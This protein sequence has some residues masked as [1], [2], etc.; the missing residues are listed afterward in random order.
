MFTL[1]Y[2]EM[3]THILYIFFGGPWVVLIESINFMN[4][5]TSGK[6]CH[7]NLKIYLNQTIFFAW[8]S[9]ESK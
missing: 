9:E 2:F 5:F 7:Y 1:G 8:S 3:F 4:G 6:R